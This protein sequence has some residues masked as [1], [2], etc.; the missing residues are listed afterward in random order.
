MLVEAARGC[1]A[2]PLRSGLGALAI[3]VAVGTMAVVVT[4]LDGFAR[5]TQ[6]ASARCV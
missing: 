5:Y 4:G 3:A 1:A 2:N 6:R